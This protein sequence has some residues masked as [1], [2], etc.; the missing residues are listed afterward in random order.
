[1]K[2]T[3]LFLFA[4]F[5]NLIFNIVTGIDVR[6]STAPPTPGWLPSK[7]DPKN[8]LLGVNVEG[9]FKRS[10]LDRDFFLFVY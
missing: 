6:R 2:L 1:M 4:I 7:V 10:F 9:K 5:C 8:I 3:K